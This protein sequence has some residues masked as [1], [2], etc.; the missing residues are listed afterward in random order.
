MISFKYLLLCFLLL[1]STTKLFSQDTVKLRLERLETLKHALN[2]LHKNANK[3]IKDFKNGN[4]ISPEVYKDLKDKVDQFDKSL[5]TRSAPDQFY[6][7]KLGDNYE[8]LTQLI[9]SVHDSVAP[10]SKMPKTK[11]VIKKF[12]DCY[13]RTENAISLYDNLNWNN[14][15]LLFKIYANPYPSP[16]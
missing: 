11:R 16:I 4:Y 2:K 13:S 10:A 3:L 15:N 1:S 9:I 5:K 7:R 6:I 14:T 12:F 8:E